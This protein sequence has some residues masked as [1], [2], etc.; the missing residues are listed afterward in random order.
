M[1]LP[2]DITICIRLQWVTGHDSTAYDERNAANILGYGHVRHTR[3]RNV[4]YLNVQN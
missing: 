1:R 3:H 4:K 2:Q